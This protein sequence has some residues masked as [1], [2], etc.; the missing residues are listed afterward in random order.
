[1][2]K[3]YP[4]FHHKCHSEIYLLDSLL[5]VFYQFIF[6]TPYCEHFSIFKYFLYP[7]FKCLTFHCIDVCHLSTSSI[8]GS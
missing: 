7:I 1:M 5:Y 4:L 8:I 3:D 2:I 6:T